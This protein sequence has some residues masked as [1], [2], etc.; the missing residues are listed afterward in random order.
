MQTPTPDTDP[1]GY[2]GSFVTL[3][4]ALLAL[5]VAFGVDLTD[6]QTAAILGVATAAGP[7]VTAWLIRRRAW[8]PDTHRGALERA[9][10]AGTHDNRL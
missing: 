7:L 6:T 4:G 1:S 5:L 8:A 3:I 10:E 2:Y 9:Y